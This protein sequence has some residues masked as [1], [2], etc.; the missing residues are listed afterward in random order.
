MV[1][2]D[3]TWLRAAA[4]IAVVF[5]FLLPARSDAT[6]FREEIRIAVPGNQISS[7]VG[8][9]DT[10]PES[11]SRTSTFT[12]DVDGSG[13]FWTATA[14]TA[15]GSTPK[16]QIGAE[17]SNQLAGLFDPG[18][19]YEVTARTAYDFWIFSTGAVPI[20]P[21]VLIP[22]VVSAQGSASIAIADPSM[23]TIGVSASLQLTLPDPL[24]GNAP[25]SSASTVAVAS[26][27]C[28]GGFDWCSLSD[29][30]TGFLDT[31]SYLGTHHYAE[32]SQVF[33]QLFA[34]IAQPITGDQVVTLDGMADPLI[35]IDPTATFLDEGGN[36]VLFTDAFE[37]YFSEGILPGG[38]GSAVPA[39]G[40]LG[41]ALAGALLVYAAGQAL[42]KPGRRRQGV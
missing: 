42:R 29:Y 32:N 36:P 8:P 1:R 20:P 15:G 7:E 27:G 12:N 37:L 30:T 21:G 34:R 40:P 28:P 16:A 31:F 24:L 9:D 4:G 19:L 5:L 26:V 3:F 35:Y 11:I 22:I 18:K 38:P 41:L 39:M 23:A 10:L 33:V 25:A 2:D 6:I 14:A 13:G 17:I